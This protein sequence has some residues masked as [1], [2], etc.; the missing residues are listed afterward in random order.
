MP[1][2]EFIKQKPVYVQQKKSFFCPICEK[3]IQI[4]TKTHPYCHIEFIWSEQVIHTKDIF[5]VRKVLLPNILNVKVISE[6][7]HYHENTIY[8][9]FLGRA[10]LNDTIREYL[11]KALP[12]HIENLQKFLKIIQK[13][14]LDTV[15]IEQ[16]EQNA[17]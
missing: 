13:G 4:G 1:I 6:R 9:M 2:K 16:E 17:K 7:T 14:T 12:E 3:R 5:K 8:N 15:V 11:I 10:P